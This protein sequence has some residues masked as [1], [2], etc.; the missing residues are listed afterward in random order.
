[1]PGI[2]NAYY[3]QQRRGIR[4]GTARELATNAYARFL[5]QQ[6]GS[7]ERRDL[8][9]NVRQGRTDLNTD[10]NRYRTDRG[11]AYQQGY[12]PYAAQYGARGL[13]GGGITSGVQAE[14]MQQ[15]NQDYRR[16]L[17]R[18]NVDYSRALARLNRG[19]RTDLGRSRVNT[20]QEMNQYNLNQADIISQRNDALAA[21]RMQRARERAMTAQ[22][23]TA[24]QPY[25]Q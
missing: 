22:W 10:I 17:G 1:M 8:R 25:L 7:R 18:A 2:D 14:G 19:F 3:E 24:L 21:L 20:Q 15:Y 13:V 23:L 4:S 12:D 9:T 6:R 11:L 5:A 16:D